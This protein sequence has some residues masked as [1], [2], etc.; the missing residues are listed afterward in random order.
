M[1]VGA[2]FAWVKNSCGVCD[3]KD[4][5]AAVGSPLLY[6]IIAESSLIGLMVKQEHQSCGPELPR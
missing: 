5:G 6:L 4:T 1:P 2:T 3:L